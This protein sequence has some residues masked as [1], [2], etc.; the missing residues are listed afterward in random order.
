MGVGDASSPF[1]TTREANTTGTAGFGVRPPPVTLGVWDNALTHP[2]GELFSLG[3][4]IPWWHLKGSS[5]WGQTRSGWDPKLTL[6]QST[7]GNLGSPKAP[8]WL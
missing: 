4:P 2:Q 8:N 6:S 3:F 1:G 7:S 5:G